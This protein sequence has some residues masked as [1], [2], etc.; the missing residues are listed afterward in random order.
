VASRLFPL[1]FDA[2]DVRLL[3]GAATFARADAWQREGHVTE[4]VASLG[5]L[6][7]DVRGTWQRVDW[8]Q[9]SAPGGKL[10][11]TCSCHQPTL[12]VH[13]A[14]LLLHW[15]RQPAAFQ[16]EVATAGS[17]PGGRS[18]PD[19]GLGD[20]EDDLGDDELGL[21]G[22][23]EQT[24]ADELAMLLGLFSMAELREVARR[25]DVRPSA[26]GKE[27]LARQL[28]EALATAESVDAA[29]GRLNGDEMLT[30]QVTDLLGPDLATRDTVKAAYRFLGG[31]EAQAPIAPLLELALAGSVEYPGRPGNTLAVPVAVSQ[32]LGP[33]PGLARPAAGQP[34]PPQE[35]GLD[36]LQGLLVLVREAQTRAIPPRPDATP[37]G[38]EQNYVPP[39][40]SLV[41]PKDGGKAATASPYR[42]ARVVPVAPMLGR[43]ERE[44][45]AQQMGRS[46]GFVTLVLHLALS[47]E[48][49]DTTDRLTVEAERLPNLCALSASL[50]RQIYVAM[51]AA[52]QYLGELRRLVGE[53]GPFELHCHLGYFGQTTPLLNQAAQLRVLLLRAVSKLPPDVWYDY[54]SFRDGLRH[55]APFDS[56]ALSFA[57][58]GGGARPVWWVSDHAQPTQP[59]D[60]TT[61]EGWERFYGRFVDEVFSGVL[62]W[63]GLVDLAEDGDGP[64]AFRVRPTEDAALADRRLLLGDD[65]T[66]QVPARLPNASAY[67]LLGRGAELVAASPEGLRYRL[68]PDAVRRLFEQ[69]I[70]GPQLIQLLAGYAGQPPPASMREA[71]EGWWAGYGRVRL[72][73][74]LTLIELADDYLLPE[75]LRTTSLPA[76]TIH[77]FSPRLVAVEP[78]HVEKLIAELTRAGHAPSVSEGR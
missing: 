68:L 74:D 15:L 45:L 13:A 28:A 11:S 63:T 52:P 75:L 39:F 37:R 71:I 55:W 5:T 65:L 12:C 61:P 60:L 7:G 40:W 41:A 2:E 36:L 44:R 62:N 43:E 27:E 31:Q 58:I 73:D 33:L 4:A 16:Q 1:Q 32:R 10:A 22:S 54:R 46:P 30:L 34:P 35:R 57:Q 77:T 29:L 19:F 69:G 76:S 59:L 56:P 17:S 9:V 21:A 14:A 8:P 48:I 18:L 66:I 64:R 70:S 72:Y 47:L 38:A 25:R 49:V 6:A 78:A 50:R 67:V 51:L 53:G 23:S 24:P 3:C 26:R 20:D 42:Q